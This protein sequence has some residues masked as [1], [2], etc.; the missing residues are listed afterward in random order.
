MITDGQGLPLVIEDTTANIHDSEMASPLFDSLMSIKTEYGG[1]RK[2]PDESL[3]DRAYDAED[4]IRRPLR[5]RKIKP[6]I[7]KRYS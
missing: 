4:K 3:A 2:R 6:L 5:L 7:A 1:R